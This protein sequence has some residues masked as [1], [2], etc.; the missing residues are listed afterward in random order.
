[1]KGI[2]VDIIG[3]S[4]E[5]TS[6]VLTNAFAILLTHCHVAKKVQEEIDNTVGPSRLPNES[7]KPHMHYTMATVYEVLRY[8]SPVALSIPHRASKDINFEGYL[9]TKDSVILPNHW[10]IHHDQQLWHE[11]WVFKPERFLDDTGK[12]LPLENKARRNVLAFSTGRRECPGKNF[13]K[14]RI[15]FYLTAVLQSLD[16]VPALDGHLPD[17]D[18]RN[19]ELLGIDVQ[20]EPHL[21]RVIPRVVAK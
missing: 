9:V 18:P 14:S 5:T 8:T 3:A 7:D 20:V 17:T 11:P 2:L 13:G 15:F 6:T 19:Y 16:I 21:S 12:L 10:Y 4:Q 1:M